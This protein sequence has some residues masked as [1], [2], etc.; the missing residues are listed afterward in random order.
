MASY[1][2]ISATTQIRASAC[3]LRTIFVS[4][5]TSTPTI[6]VYDSDRASASDPVAI[7]TFTPTVG[8]DYHF[9]QG[10][11]I[12]LNKGCYIVISG[13]VAITVAYD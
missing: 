12:F 10:D 8:S 13:T 11:G 5:A 7:A 3:K 2:Q 4:S 1:Q 9:A 6:T